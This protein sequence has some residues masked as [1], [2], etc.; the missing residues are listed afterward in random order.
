MKKKGKIINFVL[1]FALITIMFPIQKND[2]TAIQSTIDYKVKPMA[3]TDSESIIITHD[4]N[5]SSYPLISGD[6][7]ALTP[8]R[9]ENLN[10]TSAINETAIKIHH[11]TKHFII[12]NCYL[13]TLKR[14]IDIF[15]VTQGTAQIVDNI[16]EGIQIDGGGIKI[17]STNST[18]IANNTIINPEH[19]PMA[20]YFTGIYLSQ[21]HHTFVFNNTANDA[22]G[23]SVLFYLYG[24]ESDFLT[25]A[26]N[27][28]PNLYQGFKLWF[29]SNAAIANN[30]FSTMGIGIEFDICPDSMIDNNY[31]ESSGMAIS[32]Y[33]SPS[34]I[35]N[36]IIFY[37]GIRIWESDP[38]VYRLYK[39]EN[40]KIN[41]KDYSFFVDIPD[42]IIDQGTY[43][44]IFLY[45]CHNALIENLEFN[46]PTLDI[47]AVACN[48]LN[49]TNN[50]F[51]CE[52]YNQYGIKDIYL[53]LCQ[54][55]SISYNYHHL[56]GDALYL[57]ISH[58]CS[59]SHNI[60]YDI[61]GDG[62]RLHYSNSTEISYNLFQD[63]GASVNIDYESYH[64]VIHH[65][66]FWN[67]PA[68]DDCS[69]NIWYDINTM[70][71]NYWWDYSGSGN[72]T[73]PGSAKAN[74]TYPLGTPPVPIIVEFQQNLNYTLILLLIPLIVVIPYIRKRKK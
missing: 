19:G 47:F 10:I 6:G 30:T 43:A 29:C 46:I 35:T 33:Y 23:Y 73:I 21:A 20:I 44:Q 18:F 55:A 69:L 49:I 38:T 7:S 53:R 8:Y 32:I 57:D 61:G 36:N 24:Y 64:N 5:F 50:V 11:T 26:N 56:S 16:I 58:N 72:Y 70:E 17:I 9:I 59:F 63:F 27:T 60:V 25:I 71:G 74:D 13:R 51:D 1:I 65:N 45:N 3:L 28:G 34:N 66:T 41:N 22:E 48:F 42:L 39:V 68:R 54:N 62:V 15:N 14:G 12:K 2:I 52:S 37:S 40:N 4:D 31:I 67:S